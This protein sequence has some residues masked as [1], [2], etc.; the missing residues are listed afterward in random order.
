M[1]VQWVMLVHY[2]AIN[3]GREGGGIIVIFL[4]N[5]EGRSEPRSI[6][7]AMYTQASLKNGNRRIISAKCNPIVPS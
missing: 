4:C 7:G 2:T 3:G 5:K 1:I 6:G